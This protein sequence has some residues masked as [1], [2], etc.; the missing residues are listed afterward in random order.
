MSGESQ[1]TIRQASSGPIESL[2]PGEELAGLL[3]RIDPSDLNG[4][5]LVTYLQAIWRQRAHLDSL[6]YRAIFELAHTPPCDPDDPPERT[7]VPDEF[8]ADELAA[9]LRLTNRAS[10][11]HL[12]LAFS[13]ARL[14]AVMAA[15]LAGRIDAA[16]ARVIC[17]ETVELDDDAAR[18]MA[19]WI[20]GPAP[21]LTTSQIGRRLRH[22]IM[23]EFPD[24]AR[25]RHRRG[26]EERKV[27][28]RPN[29]D[30]T[31]DLL[32][33]QLPLE[34]V[35][36]IMDRIEEISRRLK[37]SGDHRPIDQIRADV[38][39]DLL[40]G[41]HLHSSRR[42]GGVKIT[43]DLVT[44]VGLADEPGELDGWGPVIADLARYVARQNSD[45]TW[46]FDITDPATG[47]P[48][49]TGV[50]R[51]RP[52]TGQRRHV[53]ARD[54]TCSFPT[55]PVPAHRCHLDHTIDHRLG[56]PTE[57][58]NL[59]PLCPRHHLRT[60]HGAG[61]DLEQPSPGTFVWTSPRGHRYVLRAPPG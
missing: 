38:Y 40:E 34:R 9:A 52:T 61:W 56:G 20:L 59:G 15:L 43:V 30:G 46:E 24:A 11:L 58:D 28:A 39:C 41:R 18:E 49:V 12:N 37:R 42:S 5:Q 23:S 7:Q 14:P 27:E 53:E 50:T 8:V 47:L 10:H 13:L 51:R 60:K 25:K 17:D 16:R 22:R 55:C 2:A 36:R 3:E 54:R 29:P 44:L 21:E 31:A 1:R 57:V 33:R 45:G 6:A 26:L 48:V 32:G 19:G 4:H 35:G